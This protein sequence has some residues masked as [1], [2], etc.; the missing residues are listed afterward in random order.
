ME[1]AYRYAGRR[2]DGEPVSGIVYASDRDAA[3]YKV[4]KLLGY[5][6]EEVRLDLRA[7]AAGAFSE[8]FPAAEL[9]K[10]YAAIAR[11]LERGRSLPDGL[12][13]AMEFVLDGRLRQAI[14]ALRWSVLSG[15]PLSDAMLAA[16]FPERDALAV[17]SVEPAG[18]VPMALAALARDL[19]RAE[20]LRRAI[21]SM[22]W[23]PLA[24]LVLV[25]AL[26]YGAIV[27]MAPRLARFFSMLPD[28]ELPPFTQAF[29]DFAG[30]FNGHLLLATGL[31]LAAGLAAVAAA[32]S[33]AAAA[34]V[35]RIPAVREM[36]TRADQAALWGSFAVLYEAGVNMEEAARLLSRAGRRPESREA[37]AALAR[38]LR[39]GLSLAV[40]SARAGFPPYVA[41]GVA[42]AASGG[43]V[44]AGIE[45]M[46]EGLHED[47]AEMSER[48]KGY[49][50]VGSYIVVGLFVLGFVMVTWYPMVSAT[51]S[52]L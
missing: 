25:Y 49:V 33:R 26:A 20:K 9:A 37:F 15:Q 5:T 14:G 10:L 45:E 43:D 19:K 52:K 51:L 6:P 22:L 27:F 23:M 29:Y 21:R 11:R 8:C 39:A 3:W 40:A 46:A 50:E 24:T 36:R 28:A 42:D 7:S 47:V 41:R 18:R 31:Y 34:L 35:E 2:Q 32:R 16:G 48:I 17:K 44:A 12:E 13:D 38:S 1:L 4:R 30:W